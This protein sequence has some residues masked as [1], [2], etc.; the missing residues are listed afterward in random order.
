MITLKNFR[1]DAYR[2][3]LEPVYAAGIL[4]KRIIAYLSYRFKHIRTQC[5]E[6]VTLFLTHRCNL[7]CSMCGQSKMTRPFDEMKIGEL[8][9]VI[10]EIAPFKPSIT[11]YGGEPFLYSDITSLVGHIKSK[12]LHLTVITNGTL[13]ERYAAMLVDK[14]VDVISVSIDGAETIHDRIRGKTGAFQEISKGVRAINENK[15]KHKSKKPIINIVCT[16]SGINYRNLTDM[17]HVAE[18]LKADTLNFHHLIFMDR[19]TA[20]SQDGSFADK[21]GKISCDWQ[22]FIVDDKTDIEPGILMEEMEKVRRSRAPFLINFYPNLDNDEVGAYYSAGDTGPKSPNRRCL[23]PWM[24]AYI[25]PDGSVKPC[26]AFDYT[27]GNVR[28]KGFLDIWSGESLE[29]FR[30]MLKGERAFPACERCTELYR[31]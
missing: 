14:R 15:D 18:E 24:A 13:L 29:R 27:A 21:P 22:G 17:I 23:S 10:D 20:L 25:Y 1:K 9:K 26:L 6:S 19:R 16:I 7:N 8:T 11:L 3:L 31:Y 2:A 30:K 28:E 5:P 12:G 4:K